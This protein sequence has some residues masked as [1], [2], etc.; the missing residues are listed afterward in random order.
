MDSVATRY[1]E[2]DGAALAYQVIGDGAH[3]VVFLSEINGH[4]DLLWTDP[5]IHG[6]FERLATFSRLVIMQRRGFGLS[7]PVAYTP[8]VEQQAED[9]LA[10]MDAVGMQQATLAA[11]FSMCAPV[12]LVAA[13]SPQRVKGLLLWHPWVTGPLSPAAQKYGWLPNNDDYVR[14]WSQAFEQWGSGRTI[15]LFDAGTATA[16]NRRLMGM[17]ERC[18]ATPTAA[19]AYFDWSVRSDHSEIMRAVSVP[20]RVLRVPRNNA[21]ES[22]VRAVAELIDGAEYFELPESPFGA[23]MGEAWLPVFDH[24]AELVTGHTM[25]ESGRFLGTVLFTDVVGSTE[26]LASLGDARYR[27]LRAAHERQVRLQVEDDG[28]RLVSAVG[29][30]TFSVFDGPSRAVRCARTICLQAAE[31]GLPVR[32]GVHSGELERTGR[33]VTG[34]SVHIGARVSALAGPGEV[35]VSRTVHDL[36]IG[37]GLVFH[38]RGDHELKGVP[39]R[40]ELFALAE[41]GEQERTATAESPMPTVMDRA[42]L[43]IAQ[44]A[45]RLARGAV[46]A[47]NAWQRRRAKGA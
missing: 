33:D 26:L 34:M 18:S 42:A 14:D 37:S 44:R 39:G 17:L 6:L 8:T 45:P 15:D 38:G 22:A 32:A 23:S 21:P 31:L 11:V 19:R 20:T 5:D 3:D 2:R 7:E 47:G 35:L 29:D 27:E 41:V 30:G 46:A 36:A 25:T 1:V 16:Y 24:L 13:A 10:V 40:W 4:L 28:G 12:A 43:R 9:V